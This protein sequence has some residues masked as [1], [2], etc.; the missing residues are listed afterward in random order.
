MSELC[1]LCA[2]GHQL[3]SGKCDHCDTTMRSELATHE[4]TGPAKVVGSVATGSLPV[5]EAEELEREWTRKAKWWRERCESAR[6]KD[7]HALAAVCAQ[8]GDV[9]SQCAAQLG[10]LIAQAKQRQPEENNQGDTPKGRS[11]EG[12]V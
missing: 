9:Q 2:V 6:I 12:C 5:A 8:A 3:P 7:R 11:P 4:P 1:Q 10:R